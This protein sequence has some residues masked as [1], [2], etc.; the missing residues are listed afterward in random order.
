MYFL[1]SV[2]DACFQC[3]G[4]KFSPYTPTDFRP[5]GLFSVFGTEVL[6]PVYSLTSVLEPR[7]RH[8]ERKSI[9]R[10][11]VEKVGIRLPDINFQEKRPPHWE[12]FC[13]E[14]MTRFMFL[15]PLQLLGYS[16]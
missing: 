7:F 8:L 12:V 15:N 1:T 14:L 9:L 6:V 3:L 5:G 11:V 4:R 10:I 16:L 2:S 13:L